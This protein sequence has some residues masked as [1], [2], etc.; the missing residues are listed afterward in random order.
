M[1]NEPRHIVIDA[2]IR[3][4]STGR[5]VDRL[6]NYL[7]TLDR[8][9]NYTILVE[10]DDPIT[11]KEKNFRTLPCSYKQ[12]SLNPVQQLT[13]A[14]K[15]YKLKPDLV[16]FT[17]TG[18]AP[19]LYFGKTITLTHDL[20]MLRFAR[21]GR[22]PEWV[23]KLRMLGYRLLFWKGNRS[24]T[25]IIVPS[26]FVAEDLSDYSASLS[27]KISVIYE[28]SE[29][30]LKVKS[31]K[32][33]DSRIKQPFIFHVGSPFPH[34][35]IHAL[36]QAFELLKQKHPKVNLVLAGKKEFYFKE[37]EDWLKDRPH[38]KDVIITGF[39]SDAELK[40][41]YENAE[42]YVL[43]SLS[44]GFGLPGL[45]AMAHN[46]PLV[47]SNATCLPEIYGNAAVYFDPNDQLEIAKSI[48]AVLKSQKIR[49]ELRLR[50]K[51]QL[52]NYSWEKMSK[53]IH[54]V[55]E[56]NL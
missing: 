40:W 24:A 12:F 16:F 37:L 20:T 46:C 52:A 50:G 17:L 28:A 7:P 19:L 42:M 36:I 54:K 23:H 18:Q 38:E 31:E 4:A 29:P 41:L 14:W 45:E 27:R 1:T 22:L 33:K 13:F 51:K 9:N 56:E 34:K 6:L 15:I 44:E 47:S 30:P 32:P 55:I 49:K 53:Q 39:I 8:T 43:P 11:F 26:Q 21:A 2:R 3:R 48:E 25:K 35:N 10:P 5:P